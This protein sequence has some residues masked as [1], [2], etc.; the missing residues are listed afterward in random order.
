MTS[1]ADDAIPLARL[2]AMAFRALIDE[3]H[4]RLRARGVEDVRPA[5]GFVLLHAQRT[6]AR[7]QDIADMM[8]MTKQAAAKL[9]TSME[10]AELIRREAHPEDGRAQR[11]VLTRRGKSTLRTVESIY[12][13]LES[14]WAKVIGRAAVEDMR[15]NLTAVLRATHGGALPPVR[16]SW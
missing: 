12:R 15:A 11:I 2:A 7:A 5:F 1:T 6:D 9:V 16:P 8:G 13:E 14:E 10:Q 4:V 3:L